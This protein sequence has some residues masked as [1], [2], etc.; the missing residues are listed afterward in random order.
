MTPYSYD[1]V[2][3]NIDKKNQ[4]MCQIT[5]CNITAKATFQSDMTVSSVR[6]LDY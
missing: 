5:A 1:F 4:L 6:V 2:L 3:V